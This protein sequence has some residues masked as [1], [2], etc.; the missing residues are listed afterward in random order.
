MDD[1]DVEDTDDAEI[2]A[3]GLTPNPKTRTSLKVGRTDLLKR[4]VSFSSDTNFG[5]RSTSWRKD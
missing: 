3:E 4:S 1:V 5:R 2:A